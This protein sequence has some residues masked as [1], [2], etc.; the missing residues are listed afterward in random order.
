MKSQIRLPE[1]YKALLHSKRDLAEVG[2]IISEK[3]HIHTV[4]SEA[5]CPNIGKCFKS[6][7]ATF[8]VMGSKCTRMCAF[9][10]IEKSL[11]DSLDYRE[12]DE[13]IEAIGMMNLD[14]TVITSVT[15]D[16][17]E[18]GGASYFDFLTNKIKGRYPSIKIETLVPDFR[19]NLKNISKLSLENIDVFNHNLETVKLL[20]PLVRFKAD[21]DFSLSML[22]EAK[23][24]GFITKTGIMVGLGETK[25]ELELLFKDA[26]AAAVDIITIGQYFMPSK[27]HFQ[28]KK[29]YLTEEFEELEYLAV[30]SGIKKAVSGV[31]VR[32]SYNAYETYKEVKNDE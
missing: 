30:K 15:R 31:F 13:V 26:S 18:D 28:V 1:E 17:L 6:G 14:Y 23:R 29:Y 27:N 4:C 11:P 10:A 8:L 5:K 12:A 19:Q 24:M 2:F 3:K 7:T 9:C 21:Y 32:S 20:Y 22:R 25:E 16:D